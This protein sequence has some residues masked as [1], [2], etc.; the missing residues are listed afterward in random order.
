MIVA[1][2]IRNPETEEL[3]RIVSELTG[4][5]KTHAVKVALRERLNQIQRRQFSEFRIQELLDIAD[6]CSSL[7]TL[8]N[9]S[10]NEIL[11]YD[12]TGLPS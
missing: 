12:V 4:E 7:P 8:D 1:L 10:E 2:N 11:G 9:R 6:H 3:A 5:S